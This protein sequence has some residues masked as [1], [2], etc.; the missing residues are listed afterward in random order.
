MYLY[1]ILINI[2]LS[3]MHSVWNNTVQNNNIYL[4]SN[5]IYTY[6][7]YVFIDFKCASTVFL[8]NLIN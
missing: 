2:F 7:M 6:Y 8:I 3:G 4:N 5:P 1:L